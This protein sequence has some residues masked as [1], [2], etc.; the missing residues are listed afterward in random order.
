M[1]LATVEDSGSIL[2]IHRL[3]ASC[4][5]DIQNNIKIWVISLLFFS[6]AY[7][8]SLA[9]NELL[10]WTGSRPLN[11]FL[12][13]AQLFQIAALSAIVITFGNKVDLSLLSP[14]VFTF[15]QDKNIF[16]VDSRFVSRL[17]KLSVH[18]QDSFGPSRRAFRLIVTDWGKDY[19][20]AQTQRYTTAT[21]FGKEYSYIVTSEGSQQ[22]YW[23]RRWANYNGAKTGF[24]PGWP[25]Y[26]EIFALHTE[27]KNFIN[28]YQAF[29]NS[30]A[31]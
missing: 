22:K 6:G 11:P 1:R 3:N 10:K 30:E 29:S 9:L 4:I 14:Q 21:F 7:L 18:L 5:A 17:D 28:T 2:R 26:Q 16:S 19:V 27:L 12:T 23:F 24:D 15:D 20:I 13:P 31:L 25:D 8:L